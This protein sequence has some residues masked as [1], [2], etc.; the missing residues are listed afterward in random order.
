M[1]ARVWRG[2][3]SRRMSEEYLEYLQATGVQ[4]YQQINGNQGVYILR[5]DQE[6]NTEFTIITLWDSFDSIRSFAGRGINTAVYY[7]RDENY[8]LELE[9][10]VEHFEVAAHAPE[11]SRK[12]E[13]SSCVQMS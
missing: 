1:I 13:V 11:Y 7:P 6:V 4:G 9:P 5:R 8:L 10:E 12:R 3:T 2:V